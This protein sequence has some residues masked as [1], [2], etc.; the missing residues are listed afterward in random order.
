MNGYQNY[1]TCIEIIY[2]LNHKLTT[3]K[4]DHLNRNIGPLVIIKININ[5][6]QIVKHMQK[7]YFLIT[8]IYSL[9]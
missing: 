6:V 3:L 5:I 9:V 4:Q 1:L 7:I 2:K 8:N